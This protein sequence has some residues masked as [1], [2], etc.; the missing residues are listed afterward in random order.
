MN[1][2]PDKQLFFNVPFQ[3]TK[4]GKKELCVDNKVRETMGKVYC[5]TCRN[6]K[7]NYIPTNKT[8]SFYNCKKC[9][10]CCNVLKIPLRTENRQFCCLAF[11]GDGTYCSQESASTKSHLHF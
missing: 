11:G 10:T 6:E 2:L 9:K 3:S 8:T 1:L 7:R 4:Y 5:P